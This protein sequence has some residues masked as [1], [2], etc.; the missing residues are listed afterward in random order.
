M[1]VL[2]Y[3]YRKLLEMLPKL[4]KLC[5][6][7]GSRYVT[8]AKFIYDGGGTETGHRHVRRTIGMATFLITMRW[9]LIKIG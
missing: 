6:I 4:I 9:C 3:K 5:A 1:C 7:P 2:P 8:P